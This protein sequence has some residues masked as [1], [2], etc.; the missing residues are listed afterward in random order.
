MEKFTTVID[1]GCAKELAIKNLP[2]YIASFAAGAVCIGL[3]FVFSVINNNWG[4]VLNIVMLVAGV[5][6]IA[7]GSYMIFQVKKAI[8]EADI[9]KIV[10]VSDFQDEYVSM[11]MYNN[12]GELINESKYYYKD[13]LSY[14]ERGH[15][16][17]LKVNQSAYLPVK[18]EPG[19]VELLNSKGLPKK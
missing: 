18:K 9:K 19:L 7:L 1:S 8:K 14:H 3:Y 13:L 12:I 15:Y 6:C 5:L 11:E 16:V 2:L 4:D 10:A 17:F